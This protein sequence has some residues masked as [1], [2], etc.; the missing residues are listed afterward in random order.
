ML[1]EPI[2]GYKST[3]RILELLLETPRKA[4]SR[5]EL[6]A[7]TLLGNAP[8]SEG[9]KRLTAAALIIKDKK[10][11]KESYFMNLGNET[12]QLLQRLWEKERNDLR[13]LDYNTKIILSEITRQL[14]NMADIEDLILFGSHAKGTASVRSDIDLAV[15]F[16][17]RVN[18]EL[19]MTKIV[20]S[21]KEKFDKEI[22]LHY[23]TKKNF[24]EKEELAT[25]IKQE[26]LSLLR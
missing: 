25:E 18:M 6:F 14:A 3:W 26:G 17:E 20:Q 9:L 10:R 13:Y 22:Q 12:V 7:H 1:L 8:L 11:K 2:L 15:I 5:K 24:T 23:F 16:K 19:E 21:L 4:V